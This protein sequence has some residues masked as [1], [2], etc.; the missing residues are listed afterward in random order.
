MDAIKFFISCVPPTTNHQRKRIVRIGKFSRLADKPE[1]VA[2]KEMID[3]LLL[4]HQP[5][6]PFDG[7]VSLIVTFIWPWLK[8]HSNKFKAQ[9]L[10]FHTSKPDCTN[11]IK[12]LEDRLVALRFIT[13]DRS[14]AD[15][16]VRKFWGHRP[17][18]KVEIRPAVYEAADFDRAI[19]PPA[20]G[21]APLLEGIG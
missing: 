2:A 14:V 5:S 10:Q 16:R 11:F 9:G 7:S 3:T 21:E 20:P 15:L 1:L 4:P 8:S 12:T 13:D 19:T 6:A 18:I 17:G